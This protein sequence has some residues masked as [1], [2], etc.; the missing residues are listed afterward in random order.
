MKKDI[1]LNSKSQ[2]KTEIE[3]ISEEDNLD[4]DVRVD[5]EPDIKRQ[6]K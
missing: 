3:T 1:T 5:S 4:E 2:S 6:R